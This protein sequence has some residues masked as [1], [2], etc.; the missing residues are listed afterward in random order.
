MPGVVLSVANSF[1]RSLGQSAG[2]SSSQP[3]GVTPAPSSSD[4]RAVV[5][6]AA[7]LLRG[8]DLDEVK[9][10]FIQRRE[11][12]QQV[13]ELWLLRE[14]ARVRAAEYHFLSRLNALVDQAAKR[15]ADDRPASPLRAS[16]E[17]FRRAEEGL[18]PTEDDE[19]QGDTAHG[20]NGDVPFE[21]SMDAETRA[22]HH[23][24][25]ANLHILQ[26]LRQEARVSSMVEQFCELE[27]A[28]PDSVWISKH[29]DHRRV[30]NSGSNGDDD[31]SS[32]T[33]GQN[34]VN[35]GGSRRGSFPRQNSWLASLASLAEQHNVT[36]ALESQFRHQLERVLVERQLDV[37]EGNGVLPYYRR[38][39]E[40]NQQQAEYARSH[41]YYEDVD[42]QQHQQHALAA[43]AAQEDHVRDRFSPDAFS[44]SGGG[45]TGREFEDGRDT[46][47]AVEALKHEV[48]V[49]KN[50]VHASFDVQ[51]D[52]Q[53]AVRQEVAAAMLKTEQQQHNS[54]VVGHSP[55]MR[56]RGSCVVCCETAINCVLYACGHA[57][58]CSV[59]ARS[60]LSAGMQCP[61]CRAPVRDVVVVYEVDA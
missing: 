50:I 29:L 7:G 13:R 30:N 35:G 56:S 21:I 59:C 49:L 19:K 53:R 22:R 43:A 52:V 2:D 25:E 15:Y 24:F 10:A 37:R 18:V 44:T 34:S 41:H 55:R 46:R 9:C 1:E 47:L 17:R 28:V 32:S 40:L 14:Q 11:Q 51:L 5:L 36:N 45:R 31:V 61:M 26:Q 6:E 38:L 12:V 3:P 23:Q 58:A 20:E 57:C 4:A 54:T 16:F 8:E 48:H 27:S 33:G 42:D 39:H 60:L